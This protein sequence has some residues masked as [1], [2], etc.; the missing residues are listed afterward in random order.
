VS[1]SHSQS[2]EVEPSSANAGSEAPQA[3]WEVVAASVRGLSHERRGQP[4]QDAHFWKVLPSGVLVVAVADGAGSA[5][6]AEIGA[7][8]AARAV[9]EAIA[10][11]A[12][13]ADSSEADAWWQALIAGVLKTARTAVEA[14]AASLQACP[15]DL[16]STLIALVATP[17]IVVAGQVG[18]GAAVVC[19]IDGNLLALTTPQSGEFI[20]E[21]TFL[22]SR[23]ALD[24]A[25]VTIWR[26]S[27][28]HVAVFSDGLQMLGLRMPCGSPHAPFFAPLF[29][30]LEDMTDEELAA[31]LCSPRLRQRADDDLTLLLAELRN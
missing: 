25:Q 4:C 5:S 27:P 23:D 6:M 15:R 17:S 2:A 30:F 7:G 3:R 9:V 14:E 20:N 22:V 18:D 29:K 19:D 8:T 31:F 11:E 21:T 12:P 28:R 10:A 24:G 13:D 16:A 1:S 26:G